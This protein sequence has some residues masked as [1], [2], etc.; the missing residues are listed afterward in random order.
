MFYLIHVNIVFCTHFV[1]QIH[2]GMPPYMQNDAQQAYPLFP[3]WKEA[4]T[5][6]KELKKYMNLQLY[7]YSEVELQELVFPIFCSSWTV[8]GGS[9]LS[10]RLAN[11]FLIIINTGKAYFPLCPSPTAGWELWFWHVSHKAITEP[12]CQAVENILPAAASGSLVSS[13]G[14]EADSSE[15]ACG[16]VM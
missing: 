3:W 1:V 11:L 15:V 12:R 2:M 5:I 14:S 13:T 10:N 7:F 16:S 8:A 9:R 4:A 6:S